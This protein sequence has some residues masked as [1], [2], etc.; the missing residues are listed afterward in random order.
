MWKVAKVLPVISKLCEKLI[1][2]RIWVITEKSNTIDIHQYGPVAY[3]RIKQEDNSS[4]LKE[5]NTG[6]PQ[7]SVL[8]PL[9]YLLHT[10]NITDIKHQTIA[11]FAG[12][13]NI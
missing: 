3:I 8:E 12:D 13:S 10:N 11:P 2:K 9:L 4:E 5:L 7:D 6:V 1:L